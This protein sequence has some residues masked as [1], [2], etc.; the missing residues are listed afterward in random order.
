[1]NTQ[2]R[3]FWAIAFNEKGEYIRTS[4]NRSTL[5]EAI[6]DAKALNVRRGLKIVVQTALE[7][8]PGW[9]SPLGAAWEAVKE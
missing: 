2:P 4:D 5:D 8:G 1:M 3:I 6:A 7:Y 9:R